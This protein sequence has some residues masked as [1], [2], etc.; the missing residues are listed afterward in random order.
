MGWLLPLVLA[1]VGRD[2][3]QE[4]ADTAGVALM[5]SGC[6]ASQTQYAQQRDS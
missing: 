1:R 2:R 6:T 4:R 5:L 3:M